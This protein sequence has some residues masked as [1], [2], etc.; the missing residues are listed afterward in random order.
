V[1][2]GTNTGT[3]TDIGT[4]T[5]MNIGTGTGAGTNKMHSHRYRHRRHKFRIRQ[6]EIFVS[7]WHGMK[8][9]CEGQ[10]EMSAALIDMVHYGDGGNYDAWLNIG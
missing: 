3:C 5:D 6:S 2:V 7:E 1:N 9:L 8:V 10:M 4:G